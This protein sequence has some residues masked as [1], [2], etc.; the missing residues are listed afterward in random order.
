MARVSI[1]FGL[2][3]IILG[4]YSYF[5]VSTESITALIPA[6]VGV[7]ILILGVIGLKEK[8]L[9]NTMHI[10]AV[11]MLI[12]FI[13]SVR[14]FIALPDLFLGTAE[15]P[16]AIIAQVIMGIIALIFLIMAIRSFID[17]RKKKEI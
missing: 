13:G 2:T 6:F 4:L 1:L 9:K 3:L 11:L 12:A 8:N 7:I 14:G 17:S 5:G 15:R 16:W 10:A